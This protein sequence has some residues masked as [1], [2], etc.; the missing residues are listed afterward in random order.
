MVIN[1]HKGLFCYKRLQFG[2]SSAPGIF[3]RI[4]DSIIKGIPGVVAYLDDILITGARKEEHVKVLEEGLS[5]LQRAGLKAK[6]TKCEFMVPLV[7]YLGHR[8]VLRESFI[9]GEGGTYHECCMTDV[10]YGTQGVFGYPDILQQTLTEHVDCSHSVLQVVTEGLR[11]KVEK[12]AGES[13]QS[14][15]ENVDIIEIFLFISTKD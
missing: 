8:L 3:Q 7:T 13:I 15:T 5:R 1:S 6:R 9:T 10:F 11:M 14:F 12:G 2:V 4:I